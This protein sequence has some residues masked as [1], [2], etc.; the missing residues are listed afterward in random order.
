MP[1]PQSCRT[2]PSSPLC[3]LHAAENWAVVPLVQGWQCRGALGGSAGVPL[4]AVP[5]CSWRQRRGAHAGSSADTGRQ[6]R[7]CMSPL[8]RSPPAPPTRPNCYRDRY[9]AAG[10]DALTV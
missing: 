2:R 7:W 3:S 5:G 6:C 9:R 10:G 4:A 8:T 1:G